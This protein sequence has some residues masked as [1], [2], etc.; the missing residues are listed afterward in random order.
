MNKETD[1]KKIHD[2]IASL[3]NSA[4]IPPKKE[5]IK[6]FSKIFDQ[7]KTKTDKKDSDTPNRKEQARTPIQTNEFEITEHSLQQLLNP[8]GLNDVSQI[9]QILIKI[10]N[11]VSTVNKSQNSSQTFQLN[12]T[13]KECPIIIQIDIEQ[14]KKTIKLSLSNDLIS[15]VSQN[16]G[17]LKKQLKNKNISF[18]DLELIEI[19]ANEHEII[20]KEKNKIKNDR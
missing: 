17:K 15:L 7:Y 14:T 1:S 19:N 18:D 6:E 20:N 9:N 2:K 5:T 12:F 13:D 8:I 16:I 11:H 10:S 4:A 3:K